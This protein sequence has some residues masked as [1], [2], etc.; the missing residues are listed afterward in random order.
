MDGEEGEAGAEDVLGE[1]GGGEEEVDEMAMWAHQE[2]EEVR[3][4]VGERLMLEGVQV[5]GV[6]VWGESGQQRWKGEC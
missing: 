4:V 6:C 3:G 5:R 1:Q 2:E